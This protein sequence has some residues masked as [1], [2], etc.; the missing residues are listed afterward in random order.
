MLAEEIGVADANNAVIKTQ[1]MCLTDQSFTID[2]FSS[3]GIKDII[4]QK[5]RGIVLAL[6]K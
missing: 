2:I 4:D 1:G 5:E 3:Y 6:K